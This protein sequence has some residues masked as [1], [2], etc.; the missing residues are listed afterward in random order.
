MNVFDIPQEVLRT[1]DL[2]MLRAPELPSGEPTTSGIQIVF[3]EQLRAYYQHDQRAMWSRWNPWPRPCF[4]AK[5][6]G[7]IR[8]YHDFF[9]HP[10]GYALA[11]NAALE[12]GT[13]FSPRS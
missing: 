12:P 3:S 7:D 9:P 5:L 4:N 11:D 13:A 1:P 10:T 8:A 6:L 2:D